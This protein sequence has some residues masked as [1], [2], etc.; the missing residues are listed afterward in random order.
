MAYKGRRV[1]KNKLLKNPLFWAAI[2]AVVVIVMLIAWVWNAISGLN[3][4]IR[5]PDPTTL[6]VSQAT[7]CPPPGK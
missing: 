2:V 6:P 5:K 7:S 1:K 4:D 3:F